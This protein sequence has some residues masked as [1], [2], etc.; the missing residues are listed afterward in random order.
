MSTPEKA[1]PSI[2]S[3]AAK[4]QVVIHGRI[5]SQ[6]SH[7]GKRYTQIM[8]PAV[9][10]YSRPQLVEV[11]SNDRVGDK[12]DEVTITA[13]L[14]GYQRK[15]FEFRDKSSGEVIKVVPVD[16]TLDLLERA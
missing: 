9:D 5:E 11:R 1:V 14:G 15:P 10:Q 12:G 16:H 13:T 7:E 3:T 6:R 4:M 8:T 2:R